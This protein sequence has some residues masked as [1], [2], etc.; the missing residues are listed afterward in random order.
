MFIA[1]AETLVWW[2]QELTSLKEDEMEDTAT[3]TER[4]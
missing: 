4:I 1:I 2:K 3:E